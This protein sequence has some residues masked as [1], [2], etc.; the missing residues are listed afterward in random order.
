MEEASYLRSK[1]A[2]CRRLARSVTDA[3]AI[4]ALEEMAEEFEQHAAVV[5]ARGDGPG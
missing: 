1:A 5:E 2:Q 4:R 3:A